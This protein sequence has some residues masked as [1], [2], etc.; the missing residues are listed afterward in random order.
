MELGGTVRF[1]GTA[2]LLSL[3]LPVAGARAQDEERPGRRQGGDVSLGGR[4]VVEPGE[5]RHGDLTSLGGSVLIEGR[6]EGQVTVVGG[7]LDLAGD[8]DGDVTLVVS[9]GRLR[10]GATV[11]G[12]L[13]N[14]GGPLHRGE[15]EVAGDVVDFGVGVPMP[16]LGWLGFLGSLVVYWAVLELLLVFLTLILVSALVPDRVERVAEETPV[17]WPGALVAGIGG[18]A[19]L[20]VV[21]VL[22]FFTILGIPLMPLLWCVF[23]VFKTLAM[24]GVFRLLGSRVGRA[25]G[26]EM[27]VLGSVLLGFVPF[28]LLRLL[29]SGL[30]FPLSL[31]G[32]LALWMPLQVVSVG[33]LIL[34]RAGGRRAV[35]PATLPGP[36]PPIP[37]LPPV[38]PAPPVAPEPP[39]S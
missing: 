7:R 10:D 29:F 14:V 5:V 26:R 36:Q 28:A 34:T 19:G 3:T 38:S 4:I 15:A 9:N 18:Y 24:A 20:L 11:S 25:L 1:L 13:V 21:L 8:V 30:G 35:L 37:G 39:A 22:L 33:L 12:D 32:W 31:L 6:V 2:L 27:S 16:G 23:F 17:R